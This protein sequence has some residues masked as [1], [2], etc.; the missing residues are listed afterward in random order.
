MYLYGVYVLSQDPPV[1]TAADNFLPHLASILPTDVKLEVLVFPTWTTESYA[2]IAK[3]MWHLRRARSLSLHWMTSTPR[4]SR[5]LSSVGYRA[6]WCHPNLFC[7]DSVLRI[8]ECQKRFDA[9]YTAQ[10]KPYKRLALAAEVASLRLITGTLDRVGE[11]PELGLA[12]AV[13]NDK[14]LDRSG[15]A[16]ALNECRV[17]LALSAV[18]GTMYACT[19]YLLCGLPVVSTPSR[20]GRDVWLDAGNSRIVPPEASAVAAAVRSLVAEPPDPYAIRSD[21]L[22]RA[23][24]FRTCLAEFTRSL[25]GRLPYVTEEIDGSWFPQHFVAVQYLP[26]YLK[27]Y[28][29]GQFAR[30]DLLGKFA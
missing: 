13:L 17:G 16:G 29:G 2:D 7:D 8:I 22:R 4:E 3:R 30:G 21:A 19:E 18:E 12:H 9:V 11:L 20:G 15:M 14:Y 25:T 10:I 1:I 26:E 5:R 27:S 28:G 23:R 24:F 6:I